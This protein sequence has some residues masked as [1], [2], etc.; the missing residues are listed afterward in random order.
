[1]RKWKAADEVLKRAGRYHKVTDNLEVKEVWQE[2]KRY[3][4]CYNLEQEERDRK[5][6]ASFVAQMEVRLR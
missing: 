2:G 6:Q 5:E 4:L 1:L 3:I